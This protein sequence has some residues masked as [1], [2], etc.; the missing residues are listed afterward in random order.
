MGALFLIFSGCAPLRPK[1]NPL[2]DKKALVLANQAKSFNQYIIASKGAGWARLETKTTAD[3]FRFAWAAVS[4]NKIRITFLLSGHP[5]ET[6]ITTGEK[7]IL[8]SHTGKHSKYSFHSKDP[9]MKDYFQVPVRMSEIISVLLGRFPVKKFDDAYF[10][11]SDPS[12]STVILK[13]KWKGLTQY[14]HFSSKGKMISLQSTDNTG[15]RLYE[16]MVTEYKTYDFGDIP[17]KIEIKDLNTRKLTL[18]ITNFQPNPRI[19]DS[20]FRLT[21]QR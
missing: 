3:R 7:M 12:L 15:K 1:T 2:L 5:V 11:P 9:E 8:F 18:E 16:M 19:K 20:I 13:Q 10:S 6:I 4:P 14:L 17:V 21:G